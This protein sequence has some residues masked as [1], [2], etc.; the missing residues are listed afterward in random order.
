M[1]VAVGVGW[2]S[3]GESAGQLQFYVY[4]EMQ[5]TMTMLVIVALHISIQRQIHTRAFF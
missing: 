3:V 1:W 5:S 4:G 2:V